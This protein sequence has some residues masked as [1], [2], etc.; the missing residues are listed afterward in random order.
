MNQTLTETLNDLGAED[1]LIM[2]G[3]DDCILG[4]LERFGID[5]PIVV[6]DREKVI[7]KLMDNDG[8]THE[9]AL[10]FYYFNQV[11]AWVGEK[12]PAFLIKMPEQ[13]E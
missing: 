4:I 8:M 2:D 10:E 5:Q 3:F 12:T 13:E 11:G 7:A 9:E 1:A 6:Y